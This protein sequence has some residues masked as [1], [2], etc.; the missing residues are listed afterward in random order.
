M[1]NE[2]RDRIAADIRALAVE[3]EL[4]SRLETIGQTLRVG[5][6][7]EFVAAIEEQRAWAARIAKLVNFRATQ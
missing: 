2:L 6:P 3:P 7:A 4:K 5:T 1:P